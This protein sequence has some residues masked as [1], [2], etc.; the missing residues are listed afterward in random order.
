MNASMRAASA[1]I[2]SLFAGG[3]CASGAASP[4]PGSS[5]GGVPNSL[6]DQHFT[7]D[8]STPGSG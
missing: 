2:R 3:T 5:S 1:L 7:P 8:V 4:A 6:K